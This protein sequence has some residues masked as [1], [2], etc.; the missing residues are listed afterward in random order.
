MHLHIQDALITW[1]ERKRAMNLRI[2]GV[3]FADLRAFFDGVLLTSE[4]E[5]AGY[6][7]QRF[8]SVGLVEG[9]CLFVVWAVG[10]I[11]ERP[12]VISARKANKHET[13]A[14]YECC[15]KSG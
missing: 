3:D 15:S 14:W 8:R 10:E 7:E 11:D 5:R 12:H 9:I 4:D 13:H 1:D 6:S 2:H